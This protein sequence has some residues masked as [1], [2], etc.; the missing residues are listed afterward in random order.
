MT[1]QPK[2]LIWQLRCGEP[3]A[4]WQPGIMAKFI[5]HSTYMC[6]L[7]LQEEVD[8]VPVSYNCLKPG[9]NMRVNWC[10]TRWC[11]A[12]FWETFPQSQNVYTKPQRVHTYCWNYATATIGKGN[13]SQRLHFTASVIFA[14]KVRP[15]FPLHFALAV[16]L[17]WQIGTY[18]WQ[19]SMCVNEGSISIYVYL[20]PSSTNSWHCTVLLRHISLTRIPSVI[21]LISYLFSGTQLL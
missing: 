18:S 16:T 17:E 4:L 12:L 15:F 13:S 7:L 11:I 21:S 6:T 14:W 19:S 3:L 5:L 8:V 9:L 10:A 2:E 1:S 20:E